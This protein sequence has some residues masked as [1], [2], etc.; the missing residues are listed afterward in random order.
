MCSLGSHNSDGD[1]LNNLLII[2]IDQP[3]PR[4]PDLTPRPRQCPLYNLFCKNIYTHCGWAAGVG[5]CR[6]PPFPGSL[7]WPHPHKASPALPPHGLTSAKFEGLCFLSSRVIF[8]SS[9][10]GSR[11]RL[12]SSSSSASEPPTFSFSAS[13]SCF[14]LADAISAACRLRHLVRRFWNHTWGV[15]EGP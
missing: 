13:E 10:L 14:F 1:V 5:A 9:E 3:K 4:T 11:G 12:Y 6:A 2:Q 15:G 7:A 8:S